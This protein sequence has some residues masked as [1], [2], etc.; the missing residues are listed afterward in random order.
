MGEKKGKKLSEKERVRKRG[1]R[2]RAK[3]ERRW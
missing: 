1:W 2:K 3:M